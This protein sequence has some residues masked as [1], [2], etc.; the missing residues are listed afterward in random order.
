MGNNLQSLYE[1]KRGFSAYRAKRLLELQDESSEVNAIHIQLQAAKAERA[2]FLTKIDQRI[3]T[4]KLQL[5][6]SGVAVSPT[7]RKRQRT[8]ELRLEKSEL[9][10]DFAAEVSARMQAGSTIADLVRETGAANGTMFYNS[11]GLVRTV[12]APSNVR[13]ATVDEEWTYSDQRSV[14]RYAFNQDM[15]LVRFHAV[16]V[17]D[18]SAILTWPELTLYAGD[19]ALADKFDKGRAETLQEILAGDYTG[20]VREA[21]NPYK[22]EN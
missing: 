1:R 18:G 2:A 15:T 6:S 3:A 5:L 11:Q 14:H 4:L 12:K 7:E 8:E 20:V 9:D 16:D 10:A 13:V 22:E 17:E 19:Q 21:Q